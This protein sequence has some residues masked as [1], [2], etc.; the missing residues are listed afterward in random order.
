MRSGLGARQ[1]QR[2]QNHLKKQ[3]RNF[4]SLVALIFLTD[5]T[6]YYLIYTCLIF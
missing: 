3:D 6:F 5:L 2:T 1:V 4:R